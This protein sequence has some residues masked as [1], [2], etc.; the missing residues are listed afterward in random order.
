MTLQ[1][2]VV[3]D[4]LDSQSAVSTRQAFRNGS[5][6]TVLKCRAKGDLSPL[7][8]EKHLSDGALLQD[9]ASLFSCLILQ[10]PSRVTSHELTNSVTES[11]I[12]LSGILN[13]SK[14]S[15]LFVPR[16]PIM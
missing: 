5:G 9:G 10:L 15:L 6:S 2:D 16:S 1:C 3:I 11:V 8:S 12:V 4:S 13:S 14:I 7:K